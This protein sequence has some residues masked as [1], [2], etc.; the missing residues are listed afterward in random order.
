MRV[1][2]PRYRF[3]SDVM[4]DFKNTPK[5]IIQTIIEE[6]RE[7]QEWLWLILKKRVLILK[8]IKVKVCFANLHWLGGKTDIR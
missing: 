7:S 8:E 6:T 5:K 3:Y 1:T 4:R 2:Y